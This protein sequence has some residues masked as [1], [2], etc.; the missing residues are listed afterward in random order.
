MSHLSSTLEKTLEIDLFKPEMPTLN[1]WDKSIKVE[2]N[3]YYWKG[4]PFITK[5]FLPSSNKPLV[6]ELFCGCG[7]TSLGFEIGRAH[8]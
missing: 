1:K 4:V 5:G 2:E 8:V 3:G 7:G 6:V